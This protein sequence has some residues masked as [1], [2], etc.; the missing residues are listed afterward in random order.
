MFL[1]NEWFFNVAALFFELCVLFLFEVG[2]GMIIRS[3][4]AVLR[5]G[6]FVALAVGFLRLA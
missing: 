5:L 1:L 2:A 4:L 6:I 3:V